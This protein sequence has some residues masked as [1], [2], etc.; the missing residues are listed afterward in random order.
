MPVVTTREGTQQHPP[1]SAQ[2]PADH[3]RRLL[4]APYLVGTTSPDVGHIAACPI[5]SPPHSPPATHRPSHAA[6][7]ADSRC[8]TSPAPPDQCP[9]R[10]IHESPPPTPP[11]ATH[12]PAHRSVGRAPRAVESAGTP[13]PDTAVAASPRC[14]TLPSRSWHVS[15]GR[16]SRAADWVPTAPPPLGRPRAI[17]PPAAQ[18]R[19][20]PPQPRALH[21]MLDQEA[22]AGSPSS[23]RPHSHRGA[24]L[25]PIA[26]PGPARARRRSPQT[27]SL[28]TG[29][30]TSPPWHQPRR[31]GDAAPL[32]AQPWS[33]SP[34]RCRIPGRDTAN[35]R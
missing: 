23:R 14:P 5:G 31:S 21:G 12:R 35:Q 8:S 2:S 17:A 24:C 34:P 18:C 30:A 22:P 4:G 28:G 11:R 26:A 13:P 9:P 1:S 32:A 19:R 27:P 6:A 3:R 10:A 29:Q 16:G 7:T 33:A 15:R 25:L 20:L